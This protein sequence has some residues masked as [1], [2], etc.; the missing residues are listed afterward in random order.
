MAWPLWMCLHLCHTDCVARFRLCRFLCPRAEAWPCCW[1]SVVVTP[2]EYRQGGVGC[3]PDNRLPKPPAT[4]HSFSR[5]G[6]GQWTGSG[7]WPVVQCTALVT[8]ALLHLQAA[9]CLPQQAPQK[10][11]TCLTPG[12]CICLVTGRVIIQ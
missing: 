2:V 3:D 9:A 1:Q 8:Q 11:A 12:A 5:Q 6:K 7:A 4:Q 10:T